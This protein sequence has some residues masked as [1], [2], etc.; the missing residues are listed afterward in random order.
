MPDVNRRDVRV[1]LHDVYGE[2]IHDQVE[3]TF[4]NQRAQSLNWTYPAPF[5]GQPV[6]LK[7]V[8]AFP[9]GLAEV[10][11]K[12][13]TYRYK[14]IV[15]DIPAGTGPHDLFAPKDRKDATFFVDAAKAQPSFPS[16]AEFQ[17]H[18]ADLA[19]VLANPNAS[20]AGRWWTTDWWNDPAHGLEKAGLLNIYA[21]MKATSFPGGGNVF[22]GVEE[23]WQ[24]LPAR[25]YALVKS[26]L[27][28]QAKDNHGVFHAV[29]GTLHQF[30]E[31]WHLVDSYKT[32]DKA[33]N[34]QLTFAADDAGEYSA[35]GRMLCD[36]DIDDHQGVQ[37]AFDV[38]QHT[39]SGNDTN[40]YDIHE[41]LLFFQNLDP[42]YRLLA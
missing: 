42:G 38:V 28:E 2:T 9:F 27:R 6:T 36:T 12:P 17:A 34:L 13:V 7:D 33:G 32:Y 11:F 3:I 18:W 14:S 8:P 40:P 22:D 23:I 1:D 16:L 30:R 4:Y 24:V 20:S 35:Q 31:G 21:K 37:H 5:Q 29:P 15:A 41:I 25:W 10:F 19:A 39:L 26:S